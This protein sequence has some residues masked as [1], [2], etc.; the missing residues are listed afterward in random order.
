MSTTKIKFI[1]LEV[2]TK[3]LPRVILK[4]IPICCFVYI[5]VRI[6]MPLYGLAWIIEIFF[7]EPWKYFF[8]HITHFHH[9]TLAHLIS[10]SSCL[11]P[12]NA[13]KVKEN[14][15]FDSFKGLTFSTKQFVVV[16]TLFEK[17]F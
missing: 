5:K 11:Q 4:N 8:P 13:W 2:L 10:G 12:A 3:G 6:P 17:N 1:P 15:Y 7:L 9:N 16:I 14:S